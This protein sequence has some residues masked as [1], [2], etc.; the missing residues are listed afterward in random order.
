MEI[1]NMKSAKKEQI[2]RFLSATN[3]EYIF[4][5]SDRS[6]YKKMQRRPKGG[7]IEKELRKMEYRLSK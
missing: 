7:L 6:F 1:I 2:K 4:C 5:A 3:E